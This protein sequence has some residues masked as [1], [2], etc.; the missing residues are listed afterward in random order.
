MKL[1]IMFFVTLCMAAIAGNTYAQA[2]DGFVKGSITTGN[3]NTIEG[4]IKESIKKN[5]SLTFISNNNRQQYEGSQINGA[6]VD[7]VTYTCIQGDFF[8]VI[9]NGK[10]HFLQKASNASGKASYNGSEPVFTSGTAGKI[11]DYFVYLN[12]TLTLLTKKNVTQFI[13]EQ[14]AAVPPAAEI[15]KAA[16]GNIAAIAAAVTVYNNTPQ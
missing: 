11:G 7:T 6:V 16:N 9:C 8:K 3:G 13:N 14:L 5:A 15:A 2:P 1:S 12:K 4:Y 10:M